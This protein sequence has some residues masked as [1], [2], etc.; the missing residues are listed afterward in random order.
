MMKQ[1][2][3]VLGLAISSVP[4]YAGDTIDIPWNQLCRQA[5]FHE[6][7]VTTTTG[8]TVEGYC[9]MIDVN[10]VSVNVNGNP[11]KI[12]R[13]SIVRLLMTSRRHNLKSLGK[14]VRDGLRYG[15]DPLL[16]PSALAGAMA[17]PSTLVWG[18]VSAPFCVLGDLRA[19][20]SHNKEI[21]IK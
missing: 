20:L 5:N 12:A 7:A 1:I 4:L 14:G 10:Q 9:M 19:K 21:R 8:E 13:A 2:L 6:L 11:V 17:I 16:S 18:A 15:F 3:I